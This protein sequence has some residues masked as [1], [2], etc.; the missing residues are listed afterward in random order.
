MRNLSTQN[1]NYQVFSLLSKLLGKQVS[2]GVIFPKNYRKT[3]NK[4]PVLYLLHGLFGS[5]ENWLENTKILEYAE[6]IPYLIVFVDAGNSWYSNSSNI[7]NHFYESHFFEE[8]FPIIEQKFK[9][10]GEGKS[11]AIGGL[12]MGGYGAFKFALRRPDFFCLA[13]SMSGAFQIPEIFENKLWQ[14]LEPSIKAVFGNDSQLKKHNNLIKIIENF[15][16][17]KI[18]SLPH[19]YFDCGNEDSFLENNIALEKVFQHRKISHEFQIISGGHDW[20][21]WNLQIQQILKK[22]SQIFHKHNIIN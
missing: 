14:E 7:P 18:F 5:Y 13:A 2:Y 22:S 9:I 20:V 6:E 8:F 21:Y 17:D 19:F 3:I 1:S 15:P 4:I 16:N 12:S 11:R 10:G